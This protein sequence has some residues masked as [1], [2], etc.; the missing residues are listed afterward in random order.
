MSLVAR[1]S[2]VYAATAPVRAKLALVTAPVFAQAAKAID[3]FSEKVLPICIPLFHY[4]PPPIA[5]PLLSARTL[6]ASLASGRA[7]SAAG[8]AHGAR[9]DVR[10][11][12]ATG[13]IPLI[14]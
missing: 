1:L 9:I 11:A 2:G 5:A 14:I 12:P 3:L 8:I 7:S 4:G 10:T 6:S 13:F